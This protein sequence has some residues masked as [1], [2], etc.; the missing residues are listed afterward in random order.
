M[1]FLKSRSFQKII[2]NIMKVNTELSRYCY[3]QSDQNNFN[4]S[5][6]ANAFIAATYCAVD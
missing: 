2:L 6:K 4:I 1:Y 5:V 3:L